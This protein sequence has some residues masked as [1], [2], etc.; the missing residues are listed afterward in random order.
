MFLSHG[1]QSAA[2]ELSKIHEGNITNASIYTSVWY[3]K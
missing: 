2:K 3:V 1:L